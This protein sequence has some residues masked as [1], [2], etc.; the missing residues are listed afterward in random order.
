MQLN[1]F[2]GSGEVSRQVKTR[3]VTSVATCS[4]PPLSLEARVKEQVVFF[5]RKA[6]ALYPEVD[7]STAIEI[8]FD[9]RG[10][11]AGQFVRHRLNGEHWLRFNRGLLKRNVDEMLSQTVP[12]EVA[13]YVCWRMYRATPHYRKIRPHG[14]EW[15]AIMIAFGKKPDRCHSMDVSSTTNSVPYS[16]GCADRVH[17]IGIRR[18]NRIVKGLASFSCR[19]CR[20][21]LKAKQA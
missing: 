7:L 16:C 6:Q 9:L 21:S 17:H 4:A 11:A 20:K 15:Q 12:H 10:R 13:H 1:M 3:P 2:D 8:R 14:P 18:H 19:I 5:V